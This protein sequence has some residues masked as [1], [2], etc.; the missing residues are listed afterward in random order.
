MVNEVANQPSTCDS[1][2]KWNYTKSNEVP[3]PTPAPTQP[4]NA[5]TM[6]NIV[7]SDLVNANETKMGPETNETIETPIVS[8]ISDSPVVVPK[9]SNVK[10]QK[11]EPVVESKSAGKQKKKPFVPQ[12]EPQQPLVAASEP[13][14]PHAQVAPSFESAQSSSSLLLNCAPQPQRVRTERRVSRDKTHDDKSGLKEA[15]DKPNGPTSVEISSVDSITETINTPT[16]PVNQTLESTK[17]V[18]PQVTETEKPNLDKKPEVVIKEPTF[19]TKQLPTATELLSASIEKVAKEQPA[20][21]EINVKKEE[22]TAIQAQAKLAHSIA[23]VTRNHS[24]PKMKDINLNNKPADSD[25]ANGNTTVETVK[26]EANK[27]EKAVKNAKNHNKKSNKMANNE[28]KEAKA[29][30]YENGKDET[31]KISK[32]EQENVPPKEE[33]SEEPTEKPAAS[34]KPAAFVPKYNYS[35]D[36]WSP[37]NKAGKKHYDINLL[38]QIK[39]DPLCKNKP[40]VPLLEACNVM[41]TTPIQENNMIFSPITRPLNDAFYP[42]FLKVSGL[43]PRN[44]V[45]KEPKK[46]GRSMAQGGKGSAKLTPSGGG[47]H[48]PVIHVSLSLREEVKLNQ[49]KDAWRPARFKKESLTEEEAKTQEVYKKFRGILNKLTPQKFDT[50]LEKVKALEINTKSRLEGVIDLIF[51]KAIDEPNFS[52]A[53]AAMCNKLSTIKVP[54]NNSTS[55]DQ[56][57]NFRILIINRCQN[58]FQ[59]VKVDENVQRLEKEV[60]ECTDPAK[61]KELQL[62]LDEENR[63]IRM[64]SVGNVR[65]IGELYKLKMLTA[66]IMVFCMNHLI[67]K[68]EEEKLECL[69]KLLT[70]IG[71]QVESEVKE[72]LEAVFKKMQEI[73]ERKSDRI[74]SRVRFMLQDVIELKRRKWVTKNVVDSQP[75]MMDQIQKE[76]EQQ[77]RTIE[78]M[79][80]S[81]MGFRREE[82]GR[83]KRGEGRRQPFNDA[84]KPT[85]T[86]YTVD[87]NK[88]K[89]VTQKS[90]MN[91]IKLAP[92]N[93]WIQGSGTKNT[94]QASSASM[95]SLT[96]NNMYSMLEHSQTDPSTLRTTKDLPPSYHHSKSI[97][98]STFNSRGDFNN[99]SGSRPSSTAAT[100]SNS[101]S[102]SLSAATPP[103][104]EAP[105][106]NVPQEPLPENKIKSINMTVMEHLDNPSQN[107]EAIQDIQELPPQYHASI[108]TEILNVAIEKSSKEAEIIIKLLTDIVS[109]NV[110]SIENFLTGVKEIVS[111]APDLYIDIPMLYEYL[112]K[113]IAPQIE[114]KHITFEQA[115]SICEKVIQA[116]HGHLILRVI[117]RELKDSMGP[118]FVKTKWSESGLKLSQWMSDE[119]VPKWIEENKFEFLEGGA[120]TDDTSKILSPTM[121][122]T[123]LLQL[124]NSEE[125]C[126]TIQGWIKDNLGAASSEDWFLRALSQ[127]ICEYALYGSDNRDVPHFSLERMNKYSPLIINELSESKVERETS[128]LFGIQQL[129]HRLEHPQGLTLEIFQFLHEQYIISV[130]GFIA[131]EESEK[132]PEGKAVMLKALT[133]FFTSIKE[134]DNEDSCGED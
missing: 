40:N 43:A 110:I 125:S 64:R 113:L 62:Q 101:G 54:A 24:E 35:E 70:T 94:P 34:E 28:V 61:K 5:I 98:R 108:V 52:E 99:G 58:Q 16:S 51:E 45:M 12:E 90:N 119:Q 120:T 41:R 29:E 32:P 13:F 47:G 49:T 97:E 76:A 17:V 25:T 60:A 132:E 14:V 81:P 82:G 26:E 84:W 44:N 92:H 114:K 121:T 105:P 111:V 21:P 128:C 87:T 123:K 91:T 66:K 79:N 27:N 71:Q 130:E 53:Y 96:K 122:Q 83:N 75:K 74:S 31:D 23:N 20:P 127:T 100:R 22:S 129:I 77:Q 55:P 88:L 67:D 86:S 89:A 33:S 19:P 4:Q 9:M 118:T 37:L 72:P 2:N 3:A 15:E 116:E 107:D 133:S 131:W 63:R 7:K 104:A 117:I 8:A 36:Q 78:L 112:G 48:K 109:K 80:S 59:N 85:R 11:I 93:S 126:E 124:M 6:S 38:M 68:L 18:K 46:D 39:D 50:L 95:I 69:C 102:R 10:H 30:S 42:N 56:F 57:V 1:A 73:V 134:A 65:F 106:T 115:L 103:A